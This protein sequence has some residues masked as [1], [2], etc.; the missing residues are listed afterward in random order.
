MLAAAIIMSILMWI[1]VEPRGWVE[2]LLVGIGTGGLV[3]LAAFA[4]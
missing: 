2:R 4:H 1:G 3:L